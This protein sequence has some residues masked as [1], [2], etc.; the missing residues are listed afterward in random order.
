MS[1]SNDKSLRF[2]N[3]VLGLER[4]HYGIWLDED[5]LT[6][7]KCKTAQ[8]RYENYLVENIPAE[9][10]DVLD[11]GCGTGVLVKKLLS[12][13]FAAQGL[14][15]DVNQQKIFTETI[16]APFHHSKFDD[17]STDQRFDCIV[18]SES[19]QYININKLFENAVSMLKP[20]GYLMICDYFTLDEASGEM[21]KS[22]HNYNAFTKYIKEHGFSVVKEEDITDQVTKTLD[23]GK[24]FVEK[25]LIAIDIG[26]DKIRKKHP[27]ISKFIMYWFRNK[28]DS[29]NAQMD[30]LDSNKFKQH[31][32]YRFMLLKK[33][34]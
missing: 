13:G 17:F 14:S 12:E 25:T 6:L 26:T 3:E 34:A 31:K 10:K 22:G 23:L 33:E 16:D 24:N 2:Y 18:M 20:E 8:M 15:P 27:W 28:I 30:L 19:C 7:E 5:E 21:K 11:V 32:T 9:V 1:K 29:V 4:L